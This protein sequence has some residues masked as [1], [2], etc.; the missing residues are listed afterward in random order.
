M[1]ENTGV[2]LGLGWTMAEL[3]DH[4]FV[5][6]A[7]PPDPA[8][9]GP[10][11]PPLRLPGVSRLTPAQRLEMRL[12]RIDAALAALG[13][14]FTAAEQTAP[15]TRAVRAQFTA[16]QL[17]LV[18]ARRAM[19]ALHVSILAGL[20]AADAG[21]GKA[22]GL[23]RALADT[24]QQANDGDALKER[25]GHYRL[26]NL[27]EWLNDLASTLPDHAAKGVLGSLTRWEAWVANATRVSAQEYAPARAPVNA[28]VRRQGDM[29]RSVLCG[30]KDPRDALVP[31]D[32]AD[33]AT[34]VARRGFQL[35]RGVLA[36]YAWIVVLLLAAVVLV[37]LFV[38]QNP[39]SRVVTSVAAAATVLGI[40]W[41]GVGS[42]AEKLLRA[43]GKPLWG[44]EVDAAVGDAI[45]FLPTVPVA[46]PDPDLLLRT[47][48]YLRACAIASRL[49]WPVTPARLIAALREWPGP[50]P[51]RPSWS[52]FAMRSGRLL[53]AP[54]DDEVSYWL[55]WAIVA[56]FLRSTEE[57][58][59]Y[60]LSPEGARL[61][62]IPA[63]AEGAVRA[64][65][66]AARPNTALQ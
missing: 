45:T 19:R 27:R 62:A 48:Q 25:F 29:W 41:K 34:T 43:V 38:V 66:T 42:V 21:L 52:D 63:K 6:N 55:A 37:V 26:E 15:T 32:Y 2:A 57:P 31:G 44:A 16:E 58:G 1:A 13:P 64:A 7:P 49:Q 53:R 9:P 11:D 17:D 8:A 28:I 18:A 24:C 50:G 4:D 46:E 51:D 65:I 59:S 56:G 23:G 54:S 10:G 33:A 35:G 20:T 14:T 61:A 5:V 40:T 3:Y 12:E 36:R 47:P 30:E 22:Y 39:T 60:E